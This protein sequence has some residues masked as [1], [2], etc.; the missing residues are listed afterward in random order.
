MIRKLLLLFMSVMVGQ[1][2][3]QSLITGKV[4]SSDDG[5][6]LIG[7][8][9]YEKGTTNGTVS[10][11]DGNYSLQLTQENSTVVFSF[12]GF[13][14][15]EITVEPGQT[16]LNV[17]L[18]PDGI[19]I[20]EVVVVGYG[21][22]QKS[23]LT[24]SISKL[25]ND[26]LNEIPVS[27]PEDALVGKISGVTI[28]STDASAGA[29]PTI[30][31][32]GIGSITADASPLIVLDGVV[33]DADYL[34][35]MNMDDVESIEVLK[36]AA[37]SA[38]YGSRGGN[39]VIMITTKQGKEG[40]PVF[41]FKA[42]YGVRFTESFD[43]KFYSIS[44]W[45]DKVRA[46][47]GGE[48]TDPM[49]YIMELG[50]ETDWVDEIFDGGII[51]S[52][53]LSARGGTEKT[54]YSVS[55]GYLEDEG[56]LLTDNF[57]KVNLRLK[58]DTKINDVV[59]FGASVSPSYSVK[60]DF[61][62]R[63]QDALRQ[64]PWLP[65]YHDENTIQYVDRNTYP[66]V[67]VGDYAMERH[68]DN[69]DLYGNGS[70]VD[71][72]TTSNVNPYAKV[73]EREFKTYKFQLYS[74]GYITLNFNDHLSL[75]SSLALNYSTNRDEDWQGS[76]SHRNGASAVYSLSTNDVYYH[77]VNE[78]IFNYS[79]RFG[80]HTIDAVAGI[81]FEKWHNVYSD[82]EGTGYD[83]DY[84]QT[85]NAATSI[86]E[87]MTEKAEETMQSFISRFNY[88]Y[89]NR[90]LLSLSARWDGSSRFGE[91]TKYGFFPAISAGWRISEEDFMENVNAVSNLKIR[92]SY[93]VTGNKEGI[94]L[95]EA[96]SRVV[97]VSA[98]IDGAATGGFAPYN[99]AN[100]DLGWEKSEEVSGGIDLGLWANKLNISVDA[101]QRRSKDLL[102]AQEIPG[103]TGFETATM[104]IGEV[105]NSGFEIEV[106]V[107][108][109]RTTNFRWNTSLNMS[110]N[111]NEL[112]DF[113]GASG[114][115][116]YEDDK[117]AAE[118]IAL[119]G[120]P[121]S[122]FYGYV[123]EK[124]IPNEYLN[125]PFYPIGG[126]SQDVYVKDLNGD[127]Q[128]DSDDRAILGSPY[129]KLVWG[130]SNTLNYHD[131]DLSFTFQGSHGAKV[132]NLDPQYFGNQFSSNMDY[133]ADFPD[134]DKVVQRIYTDLCVQDASYIALRNINLGYTL[135]ENLASKIGMK[136]ARV[137][138]SAQNLIFLTADEYTSFNPEG[139]TDNTSPLR[140]GYQVG[141]APVSKAVSFG[142]N[143]N[144]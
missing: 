114:L 53:S 30:R 97:P 85:I 44:E 140:G 37:S 13:V 46:G 42:Y 76:L 15:Q 66:D 74:K 63:I 96:I 119:E 93:G 41:N 94:G 73:V 100:P 65:I 99:I 52:Y 60:R 58:M 105:K 116:T 8:N 117:R 129:P 139:V 83:F 141:A 125:D 64:S 128:I 135:P 121:I 2:Y 59:S 27:R 144:F 28:Q 61:P 86:S 26:K 79:N 92:A 112:V 57:E 14:A 68:F 95:Y 124:D 130:F 72:S 88:S 67:E 126:E 78:N 47:N 122:S 89:D 22:Q 34:G 6:P 35:S 33:V 107:Q 127:G 11:I 87:A 51:Q 7:V 71:I 23:H 62:I 45:A 25:N 31:V 84:I 38:I 69:Y 77:G 80:Q 108:P 24:G 18:E 132:R 9:I 39:G 143:L 20:D 21:V 55:G 48:L 16:N 49:K 36:D 29:S 123:Y 111:V 90:L 54:K 133:T 113:A 118:Y 5:E 17:V 91:D 120:Y 106:G 98:I 75:T 70:D 10:D 3:A 134:A 40:K 115:I 101:Y 19:D 102:L 50:T 138:V 81:A 82:M 56:V 1:L 131:F 43:D 142:V 104:N 110:H 136:N 137:Y 103:V 12:I 109:I 4:T 32:R